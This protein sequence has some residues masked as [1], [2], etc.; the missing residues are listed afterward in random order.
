MKKLLTAFFLLV[1]GGNVFAGSLYFGPSLYMEKTTSD[2]DNLRGL[3]PH[4][5]AGY[6]DVYDCFYLAGELFVIPYTLSL[7]ESN[8]ERD[9]SARTTYAWGL[10]FLPGLLL[11]EKVVAYLRL[12]YVATHFW[13]PNTNKSGGQFGAGLQSDLSKNWSIRAEYVYTAYANVS[14]WGSPKTDQYGIGLIY[15]LQ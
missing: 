7:Y 11:T 10:S 8:S 2:S 12:G 3:F 5:S 4:L 6:W 1:I 15:K 9:Q 13:G 14:T